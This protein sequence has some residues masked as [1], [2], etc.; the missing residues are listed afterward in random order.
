M[1]KIEGNILN[2]KNYKVVV[3]DNYYDKEEYD[4]IFQ[5][6]LFLSK[7]NKLFAPENTGQPGPDMK[8]NTGVFL[9]ELYIGPYRRFSDILKYNRK[10]FNPNLVEELINVDVSFRQIKHATFDSTLLSYYGQEGYYRSHLDSTNITLISWFFKEPK[11]FTGGNLFFENDK[12][13]SVECKNNRTIIF[14]SFL[15]HAVEPV[16]ISE[17]NVKNQFGRF[18]LSQFIM[19]R[20]G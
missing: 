5:E 16:N 3:L 18:A 7:D 2:V 17:E 13:L 10:I 15:M 6:C 9:D 14:P 11:S 4:C 1:N 19:Y 20:Y 8:K 12:N